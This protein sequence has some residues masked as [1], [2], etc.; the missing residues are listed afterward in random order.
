MDEAYAWESREFLRKK[1]L[2]KEVVFTI[3]PKSK[4]LNREYGNIF[5]GKG[6]IW[7]SLRKKK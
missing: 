7:V 5:L 4:T 3:D 2:G 1:V 6:M